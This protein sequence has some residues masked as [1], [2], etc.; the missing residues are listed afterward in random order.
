MSEIFRLCSGISFGK[1]MPQTSRRLWNMAEEREVEKKNE[2]S[3]LLSY[4]CVGRKKKVMSFFVYYIFLY[5]RLSEGFFSVLPSVI[6][7][8]KTNNGR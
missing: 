2:I 5:E 8:V 3:F 1:N 7:L 6:L 4:I